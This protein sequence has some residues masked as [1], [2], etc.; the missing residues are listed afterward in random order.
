MNQFK[1]LWIGSYAWVSINAKLRN[2][3]FQSIP[4]KHQTEFIFSIFQRFGPSSSHL[5]YLL[6]RGLVHYHHRI[7]KQ[8]KGYQAHAN[9]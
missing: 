6:C 9:L 2:F 7:F 8:D 5:L 4:G 1:W 3:A